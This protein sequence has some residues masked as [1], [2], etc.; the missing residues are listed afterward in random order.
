M[1]KTVL[2]DPSI[3][4]LNMGDHIIMQSAER[5]LNDIIKDS[6]IIKCGTHSPAV[7][8]YQNTSLNPRFKLYDN[9]EYKF[10]CG[11]NLLWRNLFMPRPI[12]NVN[13]FNCRIYKNSV[14]LGVGTSSSIKKPNFYTI[15]IYKKIL[16][17][18]YIHSVRDE[19]TKKFVENL[20]YKAINTGCPTMWQFTKS[21][22]KQIP[23]EKSDN[24]IFT[25]TDYGQD[26]ENDQKLID[27]LN[28]NYKK[29]YFWV[30]GIYDLDYL[31]K[32]KNIQRIQII[33]PIVKA[34]DNILS[35]DNIEY[36]GTR[37]HAGIFAMQHKKRTIILAID[38]RVRDMKETY[39]L[40]TLER[41][42]I[43]QLPNLIYSKFK[44]DININKDNID[45]WLSQFKEK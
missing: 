31:Q 1:K 22:C 44:T 45:K 40:I 4:S 29:I 32:F 17:R 18:Q 5:V 38:N 8:F 19:R 9:V 6:F 26:K 12:F 10:I 15:N 11:S 34:Y 42:N 37:L 3:R 35:M 14:L 21:F 39:N 41:N 13:P 25:L 36:V 33:P 20:G 24:V 28:D 27:I 16:S 2:F 7:T 23:E 43:N 30:Q